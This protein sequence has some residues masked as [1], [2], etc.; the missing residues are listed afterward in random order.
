MDTKTKD[1]TK[2]V[3]IFESVQSAQKQHGFNKNRLNGIR[4]NC[5]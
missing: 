2:E 5:Q 4:S 3:N 1:C